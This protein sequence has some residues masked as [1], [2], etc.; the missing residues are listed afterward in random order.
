M[1]VRPTMLS[2]CG[3]RIS[4]V[5]KLQ[6]KHNASYFPKCCGLTT[7]NPFTKLSNTFLNA[8][9]IYK[10]NGNEKIRPLHRRCCR[11]IYF[12]GWMV[13]MSLIESIHC[14]ITKM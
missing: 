10:E 14:R 8:K 5:L 9:T 2:L 3:F 6:D 13:F 11:P 12:H 4:Y 1:S 7:I